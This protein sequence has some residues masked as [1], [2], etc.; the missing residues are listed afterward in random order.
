MREWTL[1]LPSELPLWELESQWTFDF[2]ERN[3]RGRNPLDWGI[4]YIIE[5]I[6]ELKCLKWVC[7]IHLNNSNTSYGQKKG[8]ESIWLL[9]TKSKESPRF[10]Y[11]QVACHIPLKSSPQGLQLCFRPHLNQNSAHKVMGPQSHGSP[12]L[13]EFR[14]SHLG[15]LRQNDIWVLVLWPSIEYAI[16]EKVVASPNSGPWWILWVRG[17]LMIRRCT[18]ML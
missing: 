5:K 1:T 10:P 8:R 12:Q 9:T 3:F 17:L 7:M 11:V 6:L 13:W 4:F 14:D 16:R 18:K 2:F 15:V